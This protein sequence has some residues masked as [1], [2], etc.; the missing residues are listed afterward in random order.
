[1][2]L[3]DFYGSEPISL[4]KE[5]IGDEL[6]YHVGSF[7]GGEDLDTGLRQTVRDLAAHVPEG[8]TVLDAGCGW[9]GPARML[10]QERGCTVHGVTVS[11]AQAAYCTGLGLS[12]EVCDLEGTDLTDSYD[13]AF[14]LESFEHIRDK[15]RLLRRLRDR[16][17]HLVL[18]TACVADRYTGPR[19]TFGETMLLCSVSE[20]HGM[21]G[22][23][24]WQI[25]T[26]SNR[27]ARGAPTFFHWKERLDRVFGGD[28]PPGQLAVLRDHTETALRALGDWSRAFPLLD[29]VAR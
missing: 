3:D 22:E 1:M 25:T 7:R 28:T 5:I 20:L 6:H 21:L 19:L 24:G 17:A 2:N 4:W 18:S 16:A 26:S 23:A 9:G 10:E 29:V 8:A 13:V 12:V 14:A 11:A 27:R 15:A